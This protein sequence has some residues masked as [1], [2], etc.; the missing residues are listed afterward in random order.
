MSIVDWPKDSPQYAGAIRKHLNT[1]LTDPASVY[2]EKQI[3]WKTDKETGKKVFQRAQ[4]TIDNLRRLV[5][6]YGVRVRWNEMARDV[7]VW[8][9]GEPRTGEL[10]RNTNLALV[11]DLCTINKY[12]YTRVVGIIQSVAELDAYNPAA[13][14]IKSKPWDGTNRIGE[15][16][17]C[18]TLAD[19]EKSIL[20]FALFRKWMYGA[21]AILCG[22]ANKFEHVMVLV[23]P[24]GGIGKT[25]F[26]NRLCPPEF[27]ADGVTLDVGNKDS[28][29][30]VV[31]KWLVELGEIGATFSRSDNEALKAFLSRSSDEIRP[32]YARAANQYPRRTAFFGSVNNVRFLV[33]DT[34][35]RR[36][37]PIEV[38]AINYRHDIDMQQVWAEALHRV[39]AGER[40]HLDEAENLQVG[41]LTE[42]FRAQDRVEELILAAYDVNAIPCRFASASE[43]LD[44]I[45]INNPKQSD[46]RKASALLRK[47]FEH[48]VSRGYTVYH[49]PALATAA[50]RYM[51]PISS[52][53]DDCPL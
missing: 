24:V 38:K 11:E 5:D 19:P 45:G 29:L 7:E 40:W 3:D 35:N 46:T 13:D 43:V 17:D 49:L 51:S 20:S 47:M 44:E 16:F 27:Q 42:G 1:P 52:R 41:T 36:F 2:D 37:W 6:S 21:A 23:D 14:W 4:G 18:L 25:R 15:L 50:R 32:P 26:F 30:N 9:D 53:Y 39:E 28:V 8:V 33:D 22:K 12:P 34:N 10:S 48:K 31:S